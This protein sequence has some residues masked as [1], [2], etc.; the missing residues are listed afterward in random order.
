MAELSMNRPVEDRVFRVV[1][2]VLALED[3]ELSLERTLREDLNADSL[4]LV[5]LV[6]ALEDEFGGKISEEDAEHLCTLEDLVRYVEG[7][8]AATPG[9]A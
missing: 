4:D 3:E 9:T 8:L 1:R 2:E 7:R 6:M 5:S